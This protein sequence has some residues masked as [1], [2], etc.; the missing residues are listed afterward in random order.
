MRISRQQQ[1]EIRKQL[2]GGLTPSE[3]SEKLGIELTNIYHHRK[4]L[5]KAKLLQPLRK[6]AKKPNNMKDAG[7]TIKNTF[8]PQEKYIKNVKTWRF[9]M[10]EYTDGS[11][12]L[13]RD[14]EGFDVFELLGLASHATQDI[15]NELKLDL[16]EKK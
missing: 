4:A 14:N 7:A 11:V 3:V 5:V 15:Y 13:N 2:V 1:S 10:T 12:K 6:E 8:V 9:V 16:I